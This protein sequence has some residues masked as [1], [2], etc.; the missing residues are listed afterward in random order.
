MFSGIFNQ[1]VKENKITIVA[2]TPGTITEL[3][4]EERSKIQEQLK[5]QD[6]PK[7]MTGLIGTPRKGKRMANVLEDILRPTKMVSPAAP[8]IS[9]DI[10]R[11]P[12]MAIDAEITPGSGVADPSR[13][14]STRLV[15]D[16][17][18]GKEDLPTTETPLVEDLEYIVRHASGKKL[19]KEQIVEMQ[20]YARDLKYP[21]GSLV[22]GGNVE[23]DYLYRLLDNKEIDVCHE[24]MDNM[25]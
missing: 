16:S 5:V 11:Q 2:K 17:L 8:K 18:P 15:P 12:K 20:H 1:K 10:I 24:M 4:A 21:R 6:Q 7:I 25:G 13:S 14:V 22:Y 9:E 3:K 19:S 23:D